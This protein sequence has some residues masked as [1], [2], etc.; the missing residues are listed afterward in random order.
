MPYYITNRSEYNVAR[1]KT[2]RDK[3][4]SNMTQDEQD[5]WMGNAGQNLFLP[6]SYT[7][8]G[9]WIDVSFDEDKIVITAQHEIPSLLRQS[10]KYDDFDV[11]SFIDSNRRLTIGIDSVMK[12][13]D[14]ICNVILARQKNAGSNIYVQYEPILSSGGQATFTLDHGLD[15]YMQISV[16]NILEGQSVV[17]EGLRINRGSRLYPYVPF[18]EKGITDA[19]LG[20]YNHT[21]LNRVEAAVARIAN[22]LGFTLS[23]KTNWTKHDIMTI[24]DFEGRYI[25]NINTVCAVAGVLGVK[26]KFDGF[27]YN[28]ANEIEIA[29]KKAEETL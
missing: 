3:G 8:K 15:H 6:S 7:S 1:L 28:A 22:R 24:E 18:G 17:I 16:G 10:V 21:D 26:T 2:L 9:N 23:T 13:T 29:L 14:V 27:D 5:E 25:K 12:P 20:A 11:G 4:W 19:L